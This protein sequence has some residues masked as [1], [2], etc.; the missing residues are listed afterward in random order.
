MPFRR[1]QRQLV[2]AIKLSGKIKIYATMDDGQDV[3]VTGTDRQFKH[4]V[5]LAVQSL[6]GR[7]NEKWSSASEPGV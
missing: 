2:E 6:M 5:A 3:F 7:M 1:N 4:D